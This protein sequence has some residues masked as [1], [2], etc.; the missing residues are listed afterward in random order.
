VGKVARA[1][2]I[3]APWRKRAGDQACVCGPLLPVTSSAIRTAPLRFRSI[4]RRDPYVGWAHRGIFYEVSY[5]G[6]IRNNM[7]ANNGYGV[8]ASWISNA[9][10]FV[11]SSADVEIYGNTIQGNRQGITAAQTARGSGPYGE[12][13]LQNL[14]VHDNKISMSEGMTGVDEAVGSSAVFGRNL[15][16]VNNSYTLGSNSTYFL[17][18][19][20]NL[21][22]SG[23]RAQGQD[24]NG[25]FN[26]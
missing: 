10:I 4:R 21:D 2:A 7:I 24:V 22:S 6:I 14:Y 20:L 16:F 15:R 19:Y 23:W 17:W 5:N 3:H 13:L 25:T 9:G 18:R 26:R 1:F 8:G 12:Y 11:V